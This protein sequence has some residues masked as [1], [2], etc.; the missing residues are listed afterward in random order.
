MLHLC[1]VV[2]RFAVM[3][4]CAP[5]LRNITA[6]CIIM[7]LKCVAT[8]QNG[9]QCYVALWRMGHHVTYYSYKAFVYLLVYV[10]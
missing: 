8:K 3:L 5:M 10:N 6:T 7:L 9:P 2:K 1:A 4:L